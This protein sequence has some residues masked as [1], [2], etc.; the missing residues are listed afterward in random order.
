MKSLIGQIVSFALLVPMAESWGQTETQPPLV[1]AP[2]VAAPA[3]DSSAIPI[4]F[5]GVFLVQLAQQ[6]SVQADLGMSRAQK[7]NLDILERRMQKQANATIKAGPVITTGPQGI[8]GSRG[9]VP[10]ND[11]MQKDARDA[12]ATV[13]SDGQTARL[14]QIALQQQ[15]PQVLLK[16]AMSAK[17]HL[18][19][20]QVK[21]IS[22]ITPL[23]SNRLRNILTGE[24]R[25][26]WNE[27]T[28]PP[29]RGRLTPFSTER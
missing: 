1:A 6:K 29:F 18:S 2:A 9:L 10:A 27:M 21:K 8:S 25:A 19:G 13:L 20:A 24:Q 7:Q 11:A 26:L 23:D 5:G 28:G 12:L 16:P 22:Q 17:L 4:D 14:K 3:N 15:G